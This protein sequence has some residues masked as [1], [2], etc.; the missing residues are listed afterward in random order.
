MNEY[1]KITFEEISKELCGTIGL[2]GLNELNIHVSHDD[3]DG[4]GCNIVLERVS[5]ANPI[6]FAKNYANNEYVYCALA[7]SYQKHFNTSKL[8]AEVYDYIDTILSDELYILNNSITHNRIPVYILIT[9]LGGLEIKELE[10]RFKKYT[11]N[12]RIINFIIVDHH[13]TIYTKDYGDTYGQVI[14]KHENDDHTIKTWFFQSPH[15]SATLHLYNLLTYQPERGIRTYMYYGHLDEFARAVSAYDTGDFG[16]WIMPE[17]TSEAFNKV[18]N[19][20]KLNMLYAY[21]KK[22]YDNGNTEAMRMFHKIIAELINK[23]KPNRSNITN[24]AKTILYNEIVDMNKK[25]QQQFASRVEVHSTKHDCEIELF[26]GLTMMVEDPWIT[27]VAVIIDD[28]INTVHY[29][30]S[31]Y[32]KAYLENCNGTHMLMVRVD[33]VDSKAVSLRSIT[34]DVDCYQIAVAHGGGGHIRAAGFPLP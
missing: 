8:N 23:K 10:E 3:L 19:Q 31:M 17:F 12:G 22:S 5:K 28:D 32:A 25:Y 21:Y 9:D 2:T 15:A 33:T 16:N 29:P 20:A 4:Y 24:V 34:N 30:F 26:P 14:I 11:T 7:D 1:Q 27:E 18:S 6:P 13:R